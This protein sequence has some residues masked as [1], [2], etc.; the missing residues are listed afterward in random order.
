MSFWQNIPKPIIGLAP[1]DGVTDVA[2]REMVVKYSKPSVLYSEFTNVQG[3]WVGK[4]EVFK[5]LLFTAKQRPIVAQLFGAEPNYFYKAAHI[6]AQLGFDGIDINMGCPAK[7]IVGKNGGASLITQP[8]LAQ[9]IIKATQKGVTDWFAGQ[10][11]SN[12]EL[13]RD[14]ISWIKS[15]KIPSKEKLLIPVSVKTRLGFDKNTVADW[16]DTLLQSQPAAICVHGRTFKQG[17][18]GQADWEAIASVASKIRKSGVMYLGNGDIKNYQEALDKTQQYQLDGVLVGQAT[19]GNPWFFSRKVETIS[20]SE[21]I[22]VLLEQ[23]QLH[24]KLKGEKRFSELKKHFGW[25]C[26]GFDGAKELRVRLMQV[27]NF[28]QM[29]KTLSKYT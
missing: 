12:L 5:S 18:A 17:Y 28:L 13:D 15:H 24:I 27:D 22:K 14:K 19:F 23:S 25:Y 1:M 29:K 10:T 20:A 2:F 4:L 21:K 7:N 11:L 9:K 16:T 8:K 3:L 6:V 26:K